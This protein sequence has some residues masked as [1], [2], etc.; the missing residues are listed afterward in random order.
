MNYTKI[1]ELI[2]KHNDIDEKINKTKKLISEFE[3]M[4][5]LSSGFEKAD[6]E[7]F[8]SQLKMSLLLK[9]KID[10]IKLEFPIKFYPELWI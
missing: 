9:D 1:R 3:T 4:M 6:L 8:Q 2:T 10:R 5:I 7:Y